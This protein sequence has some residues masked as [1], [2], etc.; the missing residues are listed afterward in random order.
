PPPGTRPPLDSL[1]TSCQFTDMSAQRPSLRGDQLAAT[2]ERI[3]EAA[4][5]D[6]SPRSLESLSFAAVAARA[7]VSERTVFR[8]FPTMRA[9]Q[10]AVVARYE[11]MA[12]WPSSN[13][14]LEAAAIP[15]AI[16]HG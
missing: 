1:L 10:D 6:V 13:D 15:E 3:L 14:G 12:G 7:G 4:C 11:R 8:H 2:R 16:R 9:L 5:V